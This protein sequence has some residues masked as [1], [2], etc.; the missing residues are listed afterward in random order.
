MHCCWWSSKVVVALLV[1]HHRHQTNQTRKWN[2]L[3]HLRYLAGQG[4]PLWS[5]IGLWLVRR[6]C[7]S[8]RE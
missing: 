4:G 8:Y 5:L 3:I 2:W 1:P 7:S 6:R